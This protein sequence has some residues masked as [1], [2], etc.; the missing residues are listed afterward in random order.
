MA[1]DVTGEVFDEDGPTVTEA[2]S[3]PRATAASNGATIVPEGDRGPGSARRRPH[4]P[5]GETVRPSGEHLDRGPSSAASP[6]RS[7][8]RAATSAG[9]VPPGVVAEGAALDRGAPVADPSAS[10]AAVTPT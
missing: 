8:A 2:D 5:D 3:L 10:D 9:E 4:V 6:V 1:E 7:G